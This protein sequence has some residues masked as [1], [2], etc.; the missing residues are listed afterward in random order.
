VTYNAG[1][2]AAGLDRAVGESLRLGVTAGYSAGT[3]WVSGFS[4]EGRT[5]TV[6]VDLYGNYAQGAVYADGLL[7]Y[8]YSWNQMWRRS[9]CRV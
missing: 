5:D 3:Q 8:A 2:F 6:Q 4:V 1:G 7:G 9:C